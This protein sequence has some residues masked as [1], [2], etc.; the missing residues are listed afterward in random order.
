MDA[1]WCPG[2]D[3]GRG[4]PASRTALASAAGRIVA[5]SRPSSPGMTFR[6]APGA[7]RAAGTS[8]E[9]GGERAQRHDLR[10]LLR[11]SCWVA[12]GGLTCSSRRRGFS[13]TVVRRSPGR[14]RD[15]PLAGESADAVPARLFGAASIVFAVI[16]IEESA[17]PHE[18]VIV[19]AIYLTVGLSVFAHGLTAAPPAN[20]YAQWFE[21]TRDKAPPLDKRPGGGATCADSCSEGR[22]LA[23]RFRTSPARPLIFELPARMAALAPDQPACAS[24][25]NDA[26]WAVQADHKATA[27]PH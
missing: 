19:L 2:R 26:V 27:G 4:R 12:L 8:R 6:L 10:R 13:L 20:R 3:P 7:T 24:R 11:R 25:R 5:S 15:G 9:A 1:A 22:R 18:H 21:R 16:V 23:S 14:D 17:L